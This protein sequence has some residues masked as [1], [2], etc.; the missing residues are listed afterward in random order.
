[1]INFVEEKNKIHFEIN[2]EAASRTGLNISPELLKLAKLVK[3]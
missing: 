1:M 2:V 3:S